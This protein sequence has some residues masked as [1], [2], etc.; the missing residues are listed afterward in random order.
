MKKIK[1]QDKTLDVHVGPT[2]RIDLS[3]RKLKEKKKQKN[4]FYFPPSKP[5]S[6]IVLAPRGR[7]TRAADP[8]LLR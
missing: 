6:S 2:M 3:R 7:P 1:G 5:V 4:V 8:P